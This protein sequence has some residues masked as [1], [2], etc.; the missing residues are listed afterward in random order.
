MSAAQDNIDYI[1][2]EDTVKRWKHSSQLLSIVIN[3]AFQ[4]TCRMLIER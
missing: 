4:H 3:V 1:V 2:A